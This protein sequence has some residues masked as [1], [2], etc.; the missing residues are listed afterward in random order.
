MMNNQYIHNLVQ[1]QRYEAVRCEAEQ[2][3]LAQEVEPLNQRADNLLRQVVA[4]LLNRL[5]HMS[6][7]SGNSHQAHEQGP[8]H[9]G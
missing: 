8:L 6:V 9:I 4:G 1:K 5:S 3:G 2:W 7:P